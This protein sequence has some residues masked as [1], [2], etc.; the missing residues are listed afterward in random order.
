MKNWEKAETFAE[1]VRQLVAS[2]PPDIKS[3]GLRM[4]MA[5]QKA[6]YDKAIE[7]LLANPV[8]DEQWN[9]LIQ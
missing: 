9:M 6:D 1:A 3:L 7:M 4:K 5:V 8:R 2:A